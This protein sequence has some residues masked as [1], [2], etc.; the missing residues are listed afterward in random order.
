[1]T[2]EPIR[3]PDAAAVE[4]VLA[5][6]APASADRDLAAALGCAFPG[7]SFT[8]AAIDDPY[9][10]DARTV[11]GADGARLGD[12]R[13]WIA[14]ELD[15]TGGDLTAF[16]ERRRD[17]AFQFAEWRGCSAFATAATGPGT[18]DFV[19]IALG[20]E[21]EWLAGPV[22]D[23]HYRPSSVEHLMEPSWVSRDAPTAAR[24]LAGEKATTSSTRRG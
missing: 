15:A 12:H 7:F 20:R 13:A 6:L 21:T 18:A 10:R 2:I 16:W 5:T 8:V 19:Q 1:M 23:P 4:T 11:L 22:V 17:G 24:P 14:R 9:W 3:L